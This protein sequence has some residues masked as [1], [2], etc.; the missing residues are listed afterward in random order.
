MWLEE[1]HP[2]Y[3]GSTAAYYVYSDGTSDRREEGWHSFLAMGGGYIPSGHVLVNFPSAVEEFVRSQLIPEKGPAFRDIPLVNA[4]LQL[5][6]LKT[7]RRERQ[8]DTV[9]K[10][11]RRGWY[12]LSIDQEGEMHEKSVRSVYVLGHPEED[13]V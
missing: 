13:A 9:N 5:A 10:Y 12:L 2:P 4:L 3:F 8:E 7:V 6:S 1:T 11:L